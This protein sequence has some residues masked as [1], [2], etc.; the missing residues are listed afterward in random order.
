MV[1]S[2][3]RPS[4]QMWLNHFPYLKKTISPFIS[5]YYVLEALPALHWV[6]V[7]FK[8][9]PLFNFPF[10][11]EALRGKI[12]W[13]WLPLDVKYEPIGESNRQIKLYWPS[14]EMDIETDII[15]WYRNRNW[16]WYLP[17]IE[18]ET[19]FVLELSPVVP[20]FERLEIF[21]TWQRFN[22][23][24]ES[25]NAKHLSKYELSWVWDMWNGFM[26]FTDRISGQ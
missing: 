9:L 16:N 11:W 1:G 2:V 8:Y 17:N 23:T 4:N 18:I 6:F 13:N 7:T 20:S 15:Y 12:P 21:T 3:P 19:D 24:S 25:N 10:L 14:L 5:M 22:R 26:N